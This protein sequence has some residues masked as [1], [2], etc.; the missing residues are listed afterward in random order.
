MFVHTRGSVLIAFLM[1]A[2]IN[3]A[4]GVAVGLFPAAGRPSLSWLLVI[5]T[6]VIAA[7]L[8]GVP[9]RWWT[10]RGP[11]PDG[12]VASRPVRADGLVAAGTT[13]PAPR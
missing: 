1:H 2:A 11:D 12:A 7:A 3:A 13:D 8:V 6:S 5:V 4:G 10:R 9:A